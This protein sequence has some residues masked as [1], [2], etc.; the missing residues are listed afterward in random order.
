MALTAWN[1]HVRV[2]YLPESVQLQV[3]VFTV[4][5]AVEAN[6]RVG[7]RAA[8]VVDDPVGPPTFVSA[9]LD[10]GVLADDVRGLLGTELS[11]AAETVI[12]TPPRQ[13]FVQLDIVGI[14]DLAQAWAPYRAAVLAAAAEPRAVGWDAHPWAAEVGKWADSIWTALSPAALRI[15]FASAT[16]DPALRGDPFAE[17]VDDASIATGEWAL[18]R[19]LADAAG[20][21]PVLRWTA[22]ADG[23]VEVSARPAGTD[24]TAEVL[25]S[26]DDGSQRWSRL[27][28]DGAGGMRAHLATAVDPDRLPPVRVRTAG[29]ET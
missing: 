1:G 15:A 18:P 11:S 29:A 23:L 28:D 4:E 2:D 9:V 20:I 5:P 22:Q 8:F 24:S 21:L 13:R 10:R 16:A 19:R 14:D 27:A 7:L 17:V 25:V 12:A 3:T 6:L 26:F